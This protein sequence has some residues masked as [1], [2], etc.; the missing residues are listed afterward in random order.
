L[1][2]T[3]RPALRPPQGM[4]AGDKPAIIPLMD[5]LLICTYRA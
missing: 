1:S 5:L 2:L 3:V 4:M